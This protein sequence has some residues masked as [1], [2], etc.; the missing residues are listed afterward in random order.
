MDAVNPGPGGEITDLRD[1]V[2][3]RSRESC[4]HGI[5]HTPRVVRGRTRDWHTVGPDMRA[6]FADAFAA[7]ERVEGWMTPAQAQR[8]WHRAS[9]VE[10][11]ARIVEIG[12]FR[13]RSTTILALAS[14]PS[15]EVVAIDPH[16]GNDRG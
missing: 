1:A 10:P 9:G 14:E 16:A 13:G 4:R 5:G 2:R 12:S 15:V 11:G 8:L 7:V 3:L 6:S